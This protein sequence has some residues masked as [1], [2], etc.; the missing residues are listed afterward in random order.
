MTA[1]ST[2]IDDAEASAIFAG[3]RQRP[4]AL[5]VSGGPDSMAMM[6]LIQS[7]RRASS[8]PAETIVLTVD[9]GLRVTARDEAALVMREAARL[10]LMAHT[11]N[12]MA[13]KPETGL[14]V[15]ARTARYDLLAEGVI[16]YGTLDMGIATAHTADDA[17]ETFIMRLARGS[18]ATGLAGIKRETQWRGAD[19]TRSVPLTLIRPLLAIEKSRLVATC[20][21]RGVPFIED[22]T[23]VDQHYERPRVRVLL[24]TLD[25]AGLTRRPLTR[26]IARLV[27]MRETLDALVEAALHVRV[28]LHNGLM[29]TLRLEPDWHRKAE[30]EIA[31]IARLI[32]AYGGEAEPVR[33]AHIEALVEAM[34]ATPSGVVRTLGGT[35]IEARDDRVSIVREAGRMDPF[36]MPLEPGE[37]RL[38][39]RRFRL[40]AALSLPTSIHV[41]PLWTLSRADVLKRYPAIKQLP[42]RAAATQPAIVDAHGVLLDIPVLKG[43]GGLV[44]QTFLRRGI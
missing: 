37:T 31:V 3:L 5:A 19:G 15:A 12:W 13:P 29:A 20:R 38:W 28:D 34:I 14:A 26:A 40:T 25:A 33:L 42:H 8:D 24:E 32:A 27:R 10:S 39:D 2:P 21:A 1:T 4:L 44:H 23:N 9:H 6:A 43:G 11:L 35:R 22:L 17:R 18:S 16:R 36:P 7:W 30:I 41:V